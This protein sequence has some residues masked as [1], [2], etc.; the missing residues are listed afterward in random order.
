VAPPGEGKNEAF[1]KRASFLRWRAV[2]TQGAGVWPAQAR[3]RTR[4]LED[5]PRSCVG[6]LAS[7]RGQA[8]CLPGEGKN[9]A[10]EETCLVLAMAR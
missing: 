3:A 5:A 10:S 7:L 9:E 8:W 6:G 1:E 2:V 4:R